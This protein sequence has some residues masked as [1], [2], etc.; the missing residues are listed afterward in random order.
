MNVILF[1]YT[2][3]VFSLNEEVSSCFSIYLTIEKGCLCSMFSY[4]LNY[5]V[6]SAP[7]KP[8]VDIEENVFMEKSLK[9]VSDNVDLDRPVKDEVNILLLGRTDVGK[10][11]LINALAN[12]LVNNT[13]EQAVN[14]KMQVLIP[15]S[16]Y[17]T[18]EDSFGGKV[19]YIGEEDEYEQIMER[20][21][22]GTRKCR[23]F[24]FRIGDRLLRFIDTPPVGDTRGCKQDIQNIDEIM[25]YIARY[26][27]LH[28][29]SIL[30]RPDQTRA[31]V[32]FQYHL[33]EYLRHLPK[34]AVENII[35][36]FTRSRS[37][38]FQPGRT[39]TFLRHL[40]GEYH[41]KYDIQIPFQRAN[42]FS[43]DNEGFRYVALHHHGI[44]YSDERAQIFSRS[45]NYTIK[46]LVRLLPYVIDRRACAVSDIVSLYQVQRFISLLTHSIFQMPYH[47]HEAIHQA[48]EYKRKT[49][50]ISYNI[51]QHD[52]EIT[53]IDP[54]QLVSTNPKCAEVTYVDGSLKIGS[55]SICYR[56]SCFAGSAVGNKHY[57]NIRNCAVMDSKTGTVF[58]VFF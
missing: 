23:S 2:E 1:N 38:L 57:P 6:F 29:I 4:A 27:Y 30:L 8:Q 20:S 45:W 9:K 42:A 14:D 43:V 15:F 41:Q 36:I 22:T 3:R 40:F 58:N 19:I 56:G 52:I 25:N 5:L 39:H 33:L 44:S 35:Y 31:D 11:A 34:N 32:D 46:E 28:A 12:Y 49:S 10:S 51:S 16:F 7:P 17:Y 18:D 53:S 26:K 54:P 13:L 37:T 55:K 48:E 24:V 47:V 21:Q 50:Q